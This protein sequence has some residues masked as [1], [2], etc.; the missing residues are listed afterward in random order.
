MLV[1]KKGGMGEAGTH[2]PRAG[3]ASLALG[4]CVAAL[5]SVASG[6]NLESTQPAWPQARAGGRKAEAMCLPTGFIY[7]D[8]INYHC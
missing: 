3:W 2:P 6:L 5:P 4:G 1:G 8:N 7:D